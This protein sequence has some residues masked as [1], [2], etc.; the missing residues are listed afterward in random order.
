M[1]APGKGPVI[2]AKNEGIGKAGR[3]Q[4]SI[5]PGLW[6]PYHG[7]NTHEFTPRWEASALS[8][9]AAAT[10]GN[11][12]L[13]ARIVATWFGS[14]LSPKA[15]GTVGSLAALPFAWAILAGAGW[16]GLALAVVA[17]TLA[18]LWATAAVLKASGIKDPSFVV[19]DEVAGQWIAL[20]PAGLDPLLFAA[21]FVLFRL[22]DIWKPG[23]VGWADRDL[24]G[25]LG[26]MTD[27]LLA[28]ALA[29]AGVY[30]LT[31]AMGG[32]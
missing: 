16:Q 4:V 24:P 26:V 20:L 6:A 32:A 10:A 30:G 28:G 19:V 14:G 8:P 29:A 21:G 22:F 9:N 5:Y 11:A 1:T 27:D 18:G 13:A 23:P 3:V 17:V 15:P 12:P 2:A 31:L 7:R 25:A